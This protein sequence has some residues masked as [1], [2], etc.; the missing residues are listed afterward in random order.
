[1]GTQWQYKPTNEAYK[2]GGLLLALLIE[3]RAKG[4]NLLLNVGPKPDG[5]LPLEQE[6]RLREIALWMFVNGECIHGV[7]PWIITNEKEIWF[8]RNRSTGTLYA[9]VK[10][11]P[12][13]RWKYGEWKEFVLRSARATA[14]TTVAVLSQSDQVLEYSPDVV[15]RTTW[16]QAADGLHIRAMRAQRLYNDRKWP[17]PVVLKLTH[18]E[19]ALDPPRLDT[20]RV[21]WDDAGALVCE[22]NLLSL[23][24]AATLETGADYRDITGMDLTERLGPWNACPGPTRN[25]TG[26]FSVRLVGL[27]RGRQYEVRAWV[28][29]PLLTLYGR[30]LTARAP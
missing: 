6:E 29:H 22:G 1:M 24:D 4:G 19:A 16:R 23:G 8:T 15:P 20:A 27:D 18:V 3:T 5:E 14:R 26:P 2:S 9:I 11:P 25:T 12:E 17:N 7:R 10:L 21:R 28:K 13:D 30:E